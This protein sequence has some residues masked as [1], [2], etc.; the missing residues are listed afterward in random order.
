MS[1]TQ[2]IPKSLNLGLAKPTS[3]PAYTRRVTSLA[4]NAQTF[5]DNDLANIILDTSTPGSFLD[6][7]QSF[8]QFDLQI[9]NILIMLI[10]LLVV[11]V[12]LFKNFVLFVKVLQ[13]KKFW[14]TIPCLKCGWL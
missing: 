9:T 4:T 13:L 6:P 7:T 5:K 14:I 8:I 2:A 3:I 10:F 1:E 12:R 11:R